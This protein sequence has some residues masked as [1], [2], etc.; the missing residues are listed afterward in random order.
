MAE[1][2][3]GTATSEGAGTPAEGGKPSNAE[4]GTASEEQ[5][6]TQADVEK[7]IGDRLARERK[8]YADYPELKAQASKAKTAEDRIADLE[9]ANT[10]AREERAQ[11][12]AFSA[13]IQLQLRLTEAGVKYEDVSDVL[14]QLDLSLL[15][16]DGKPNGDAI[17]KFS[18][19]LAK[20]ATG[21]TPDPDQGR[22]GGTGPLNMNDFIRHK[23]G[24]I[25]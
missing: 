25:T 20:F 8:K 2:N 24:L 12:Q 14:D 4:S 7:L 1:E 6:F 15:M 10:T 5:K 17:E 16:K 22:K 21:V 18:K 9:Q 23:A 3:G 11:E 13:R 19:S